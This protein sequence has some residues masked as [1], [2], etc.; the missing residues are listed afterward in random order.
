MIVGYKPD[1]KTIVPKQQRELYR[2]RE[3]VII[4]TQDALAAQIS[5]LN[6]DQLA[7]FHL[8]RSSYENR[9]VPGTPLL[10]NINASAGC[11][12]T[13]LTNRVINYLRSMGAVTTTV[14]SIG[15]GALL[16]DDGRTVHNMFQI[17]IRAEQDVLEGINFTSRLIKIL[18]EGRTN[19]RIEFLRA[20]D[21]VFW[22]E[23]G[24]MFKD[25]FLSVDMLF[26][27]IMGNDLPFGGKF[28]VTL[29]DWKQIPPVDDSEGV[30]FWNGD[31]SSFESIINISVKSS[32]LHR[33][34]FHKS[35]LQINERSR[36][37][38]PFHDFN[39]QCG[40]GQLQGEIPISIL[41]DLGIRVFTSIDESCAW[42]FE[43]DISFPYDPVTVSQRCVL[44]PYNRNV[45]ALNEYCEHRFFEF[46]PDTRVFNLKSADEF[47]CKGDDEHGPHGGAFLP[48]TEDDRIRK[49]E[50]DRLAYDIEE[51]E[52]HFEDD[53]SDQEYQFDIDDAVGRVKMDEESFSLEHINGMNFK[54]VPPHSLRL[55]IGCVMILLRNLDTSKRL[56]NGVRLILKNVLRG[57]RILVVVKADEQRAYK[58]PPMS[59]P[60]EYMLHRIKFELIMGPH[61]D[62]TVTRLQFPVRLANAVSVHKS[63]SMTLERHIVDMRDG[64]FEHG[65]FFVAMTRGKCAANTGILIR[66]EQKTV[67]NIVLKSFVDE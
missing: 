8:L 53:D 50:F 61:Q 4:H 64:M 48:M 36:H 24:T 33:D 22:D 15:I 40:I 11:G 43:Q 12:K 19:S 45:D 67:R 63:Q 13:F 7:V 57:N 58:G 38:A 55:Y 18:D 31:Q 42:L 47:I 27:K 51:A 6:Q 25:I 49:E 29:G 2:Y 10:H 62:A 56:Q 54:G 41:T 37:D 21:A 26:R 14:C 9:T 60:T 1:T 59:P 16:Y 52:H 17:P 34:L 66:E 32:A 5:E 65:Q 39:V 23:I 30:R 46:H 35:S 20:T 28:V 3:R 44:S